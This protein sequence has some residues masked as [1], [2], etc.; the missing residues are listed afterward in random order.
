MKGR[1]EGETWK[2]T[3]RPGFCNFPCVDVWNLPV[4]GSRD[5]IWP[6]IS[7]QLLKS[8]HFLTG[9]VLWCNYDRSDRFP[10]VCPN[11]TSL[12]SLLSRQFPELQTPLCLFQGRPQ[13]FFFKEQHFTYIQS[14]FTFIVVVLCHKRQRR[15]IPLL[16]A[17]QLLG[18]VFVWTFSIV[19]FCFSQTLFFNH[20][21]NSSY[22]Y[23]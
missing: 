9:S 19:F 5:N 17:V 10:I 4:T 13:Y 1:G 3:V 16:L 20:I 12:L 6:L 14:H 15:L 8:E 11:P 21:L 2:D 22:I 7:E 18:I 23:S